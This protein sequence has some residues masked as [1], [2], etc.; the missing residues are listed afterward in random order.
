V[1][2]LALMF[3]KNFGGKVFEDQQSSQ[4]EN[5]YLAVSELM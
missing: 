5:V 3:I 4:H 2:G 1:P